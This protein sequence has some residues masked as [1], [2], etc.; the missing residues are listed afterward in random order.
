VASVAFFPERYGDG[1]IR[2]ASDIL[3]H[4]QTPPALF[5]RHQVITSDNVDHYYA[6][7]ALLGQLNA[8]TN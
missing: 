3:A 8:A 7:D 2:L 6:N 1:L 4:R 5:V